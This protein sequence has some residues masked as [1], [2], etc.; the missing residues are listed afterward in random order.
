MKKSTRYL[1]DMTKQKL[2]PICDLCNKE[3][4]SESQ[5]KMTFQPKSFVKGSWYKGH[6]GDCCHKCFVEI[7][8]R[9]FKPTFIKMMADPA[10][11]ESM[12]KSKKWIPDPS[13]SQQKLS[14]NPELTA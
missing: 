10:W 2:P 5:Y 14:T 12:P 6:D 8:S 7:C 4:T 1:N 3:I 9:G 13:D 11:N